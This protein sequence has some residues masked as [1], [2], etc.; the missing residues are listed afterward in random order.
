MNDGTKHEAILGLLSD[1]ITGICI[2]PKTLKIFAEPESPTS[3]KLIVMPHMADY[4][5]LV[6][7]GGRTINA[8]K[9]IAKT[10]G[11]N[12]GLSL[13]VDLQESMVGN[14]EPP[15]P[16]RYNEEFDVTKATKLI[17]ELAQWTFGGPVD[18]Q[19]TQPHLSMDVRINSNTNMEHDGICASLNAIFYPYGMANGR[20]IE[21]KSAKGGN[22]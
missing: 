11:E 7:K 9:H 15:Q 5:K 10:A 21:I 22:E 3:H 2:Y 12:A 19:I 14:P 1:V 17:T 6:G 13:V 4:R 20:K 16:F 8:F 18:V